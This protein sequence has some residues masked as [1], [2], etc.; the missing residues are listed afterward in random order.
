MYVI[1]VSII[2]ISLIVWNIL[3]FVLPY[4]WKNRKFSSDMIHMY[5][6]FVFYHVWY[7]R[8]DS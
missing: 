6:L 1:G 7:Q 4:L 3:L 5:Q 2:K 8:Y